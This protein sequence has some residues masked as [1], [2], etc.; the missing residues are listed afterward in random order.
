MQPF[1]IGGQ[2]FSNQMDVLCRIRV[3]QVAALLQN[4]KPRKTSHC[5]AEDKV[6]RALF[7]KLL[8]RI[9]RFECDQLSASKPISIAS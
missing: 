7:Y 9:P 2:P 1:C 3:Q 6:H 4:C 8:R 5:R